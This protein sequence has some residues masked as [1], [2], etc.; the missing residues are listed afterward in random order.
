MYKMNAVSGVIIALFEATFGTYILSTQ[1]QYTSLPLAL[2]LLS[3]PLSNL[4][5]SGISYN[6]SGNLNDLIHSIY[7]FA[8]VTCIYFVR[9]V[10]L[11]D[12]K[13]AGSNPQ[14]TKR[15]SSGNPT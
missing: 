13:K 14:A 5:P 2:K 7:F 11:Q 8:T 4:S 12:Q 9:H 3:Y 6:L 15:Q 10:L 1:L